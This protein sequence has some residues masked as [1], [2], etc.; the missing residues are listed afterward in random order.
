MGE[1]KEL[2]IDRDKAIKVEMLVRFI[3]IE[4]NNFYLWGI[5]SV[6]SGSNL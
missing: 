3:K 5:V 4:E 1:I 2:S 6:G